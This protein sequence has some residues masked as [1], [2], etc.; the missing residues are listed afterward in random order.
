MAQVATMSDSVHQQ[1]LAEITNNVRIMQ[2]DMH[3]P[4]TEP[5]HVPVTKSVHVPVTESVHVPVTESVQKPT[6]VPVPEPVQE[7]T[8][9][10]ITEPVQ[11]ST[12][13]PITEPVQESTQVPVTE[14]VQESTQVPVPERVQEST[15][16]SVPEPV[17]ESTQV[18]VPEPVQESTQVSVPEPTQVPPVPESTQVQP[19]AEPTQVP[20]SPDAFAILSQLYAAT[21]IVK[22]SASVPKQTETNNALAFIEYL[23][24]DAIYSKLTSQMPFFDMNNIVFSRYESNNSD[25]DSFIEH[26]EQYSIKDLP[27]IFD[28]VIENNQRVKFTD[29]SPIIFQYTGTSTIIDIVDITMLA[30]YLRQNEKC[31]FVVIPILSIKC[32]DDDT[33]FGDKGL[34]LLFDNVS[35]C[36]FIVD[37]NRYV[38][39]NAIFIKK[40]NNIET[41]LE[42][43]FSML[44]G[45]GFEYIF[46]PTEAWNAAHFGLNKHYDTEGLK[47]Q[48]VGTCTETEIEFALNTEMCNHSIT[49]TFAIIALMIEFNE[50]LPVIYN[51]LCGMSN[52]ELAKIESVAMTQFVDGH[53]CTRFPYM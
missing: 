14:P 19:V 24:L 20:Q 7:S 51:N 12:Q 8:Q 9:V 18:S 5:V 47:K 11:E 38:E 52:T 48:L 44:N 40:I 45:Y 33:A 46:I 15:Q 16:V 35:N 32:E 49:W 31:R 36:I 13:V 21:C 6:Q 25:T 37:T 39:K 53:I 34:A 3:V 43:Y 28:T 29:N 50:T 22:L 42:Q 41:F 27:I 1:L 2:E 26:T 23:T 10:P 17:Q 30:E 4:V